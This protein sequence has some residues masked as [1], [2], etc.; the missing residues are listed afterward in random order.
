M[1]ITR[2]VRDELLVLDQIQEDGK[3]IVIYDSKSFIGVF[4]AKYKDGMIDDCV[5][6]P[7]I[8]TDLGNHSSKVT[9]Q[10]IIDGKIYGEVHEFTFNLP[11]DTD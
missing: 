4:C 5:K 9:I 2:D 3:V 1:L 7:W 10:S 8:T 11:M 6:F